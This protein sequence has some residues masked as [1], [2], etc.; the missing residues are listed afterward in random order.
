[1]M[2]KIN[3]MK[4][5]DLRLVAISACTA[6]AMM[7]SCNVARLSTTDADAT[8]TEMTTMVDENNRSIDENELQLRQNII[9]YAQNFL[10]L[11]YRSGGRTPR[12]G[13]DCS[14]FVGY[15]LNE[16]KVKVSGG[17]STLATKGR[18]ISL[19]DARPGDLVFFGRKKRISH[20]AFVLESTPE[21]VVCLHST[22]SR[23]IV[24]ENVS[25]SDYWKNKILFAKDLVHRKRV[26]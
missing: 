10:G 2:H 13:F 22:S 20:V 5:Y 6:F 7:T 9:G 26:S 15:I 24:I 1:M 3:K 8:P 4:K 16:Y 11:H 17:A 19:A 14:G 18:K 23:G 21:G 25:Q 12:T